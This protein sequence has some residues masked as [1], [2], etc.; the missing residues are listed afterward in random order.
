MDISKQVP[1]SVYTDYPVQDADIDEKAPYLICCG[2]HHIWKQKGTDQHHS[3]K[4]TLNFVNNVLLI[5]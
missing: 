4:F 1:N 2:V 3:Q 5:Q